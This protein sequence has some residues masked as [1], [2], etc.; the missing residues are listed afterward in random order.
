MLLQCRLPIEHEARKVGTCS[1]RASNAKLR[2]LNCNGND[3][4]NSSCLLNAYYVLRAIHELPHFNSLNNSPLLLLSPGCRWKTESQREK[5]T[6][7]GSTVVSKYFS[8][9]ELCCRNLLATCEMNC[10]KE[11]PQMVVLRESPGK[12]NKSLK[13]ASGKGNRKKW[14]QRPTGH[15][16]QWLRGRYHRHLLAAEAGRP[17]TEGKPIIR[18]DRAKERNRFGEEDVELRFGV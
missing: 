4:T 14:M 8:R 17:G 10:N 9:I 13:Q 2:C 15:A 16:G 18:R 1:W 5:E 7:L 6:A 11:R 3:D 12:G